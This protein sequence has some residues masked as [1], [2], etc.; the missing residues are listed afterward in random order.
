[1]QVF[2]EDL[3]KDMIILLAARASRMENKDAIDSAITGMLADPNEVKELWCG[4][5]RKS[6]YCNSDLKYGEKSKY[7][8]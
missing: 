8:V 7:M 3:D 4:A 5:L 6:F 1:M 2:T